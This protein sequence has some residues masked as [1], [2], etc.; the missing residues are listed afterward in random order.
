MYSTRGWKK[1]LETCAGYTPSW[2]LLAW[3][4]VV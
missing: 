2:L 4:P 3:L 1:G